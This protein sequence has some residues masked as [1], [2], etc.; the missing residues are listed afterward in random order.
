MPVH[1]CQAAGMIA[2]AVQGAE[3]RVEYDPQLK[4]ARSSSRIPSISSRSR[5]A[6]A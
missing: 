3:D 5:C 2:A 1:Q 6:R 4:Q